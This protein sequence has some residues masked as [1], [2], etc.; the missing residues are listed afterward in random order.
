[1]MPMPMHTIYFR[2]A[3]EPGETFKM[4][5]PQSMSLAHPADHATIAELVAEH[6]FDGGGWE[7]KWPLV[8]TLHSEEDGPA[9]AKFDI[10]METRPHFI[11][12]ELDPC[13]PMT[14][15]KSDA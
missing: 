11:A 12:Y 7:S 6:Y 14:E 2:V 9:L 8:F 15:A 10:E 3:D 13:P 1:M 4:G 5:I